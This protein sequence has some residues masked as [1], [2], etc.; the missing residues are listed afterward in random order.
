M[1]KDK[2]ES[3]CIPDGIHNYDFAPFGTNLNNVFLLY[4]ISVIL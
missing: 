2:G 4:N 3:M 1:H